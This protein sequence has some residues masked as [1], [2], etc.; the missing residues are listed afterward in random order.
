MGWNIWIGD[1]LDWCAR[2]KPYRVYVDIRNR[3]YD[4]TQDRG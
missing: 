2:F 1:V 4:D 3:Q